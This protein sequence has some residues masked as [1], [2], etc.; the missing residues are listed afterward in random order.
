MGA[1]FTH[2]FHCL[3]ECP[4][5]FN[6]IKYKSGLQPSISFHWPSMS[7]FTCFNMRL[8]DIVDNQRNMNENITNFVVAL[9]CW[10]PNKC[11]DICRHSDK[12]RSLIYVYTGLSLH[13]PFDAETGIFS[14]R[15]NQ[16]IANA[17]ASCITSSSATM[18]WTL[19]NM[20]LCTI[21]KDLNYLQHPSPEK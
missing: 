9:C 4:A 3:R 11:W 17:V 10:W 14:T 21:R 5:W 7:A 16:M 12:L 15:I 18:A 8:Y 2:S 13:K 1:S 19:T 20:S 6:F